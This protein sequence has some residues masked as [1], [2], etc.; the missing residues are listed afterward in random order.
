MK[1]VL[2][3]FGHPVENTFANSLRD[4]YRNGALSAGAEVR[5]IELSKLDFD[6]N[7]RSG[8]RGNQSLEPDLLKAQQQ[9]LW[10][11]HLVFIYPNWWSTFPALLKGFIDRTFLPGFAFSYQKEKQQPKQLLSGRSARLIVTMDTP[12][13]YYW[14]VLHGPGHIAMKK[15]ILGFCG[16]HPVKSTTIGPVR[17]SGKKQRSRWLELVYRLGER[18]R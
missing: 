3:I 7:F 1:H 13:W 9:I 18:I 8:Y 2:I 16:I 11:H 14:L 17:T 6:L 10:A 5:E 4:A 12:L 15:G